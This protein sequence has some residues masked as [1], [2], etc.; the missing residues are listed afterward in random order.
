M[1]SWD[2]SG[3]RSA[4]C[5]TWP[6][7]KCSTKCMSQAVAVKL[8]PTG[9]Q[10]LQEKLGSF[11]GL[12]SL[13]HSACLPQWNNWNDLLQLNRNLKLNCFV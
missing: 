13:S 5:H 8:V 1:Q 12:R 3:S 7:N 4:L 10:A 6:A 9:K 2:G 11:A